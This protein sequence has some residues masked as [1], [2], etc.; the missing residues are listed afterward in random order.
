MAF[1]LE[2]KPKISVAIPNGYNNFNMYADFQKGC[3]K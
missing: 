1:D 3:W 2:V